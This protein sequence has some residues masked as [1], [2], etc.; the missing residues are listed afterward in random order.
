MDKDDLNKLI[1]IAESVRQ[2]TSS[3][4]SLTERNGITLSEYK[5]P[6]EVYREQVDQILA[7]F[8]NLW[9]KSTPLKK[10]S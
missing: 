3:I 10:E 7:K 5:D 8:D 9:E 6:Y 2:M 4:K 1:R